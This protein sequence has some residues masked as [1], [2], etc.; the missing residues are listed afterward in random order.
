MK[1]ILLFG[2]GKSATVLIEYL[3]DNGPAH[4]W[5][6]IVADADKQLAQSKLDM[7]ERDIAVQLDVNDAEKRSELIEAADLIISL[8]PPALHYLIAL[9]CL[10]YKKHL[11]TAS[12]VDERIEKLKEEIKTNNLLFL[13]EMGLDPGIDHMS[14][15]KLIDAIH[16]QGGKIN[17]FISHCG[18]LVA[19][20]S[21]DNPWHYKISWNPKNVVNAGKA[22]AKFKKDGV[23]AEMDYHNIFAEK[24]YVRNG[25]E[26]YCWYP[27]RDSLRYINLYSLNEAP[28]FIRTTLRHPDF[29]Y[30]WKNVVDLKLTDENLFYETDGCSLMAFFKEHMDRN[31]FNQWLEQKLKQQFEDTQT[32]LNNLVNLV[33]L[34]EQASDEAEPIDDLMMVNEKGDLQN[35]DMDDLKNNAA[36]TIAFKMH[37]SKLT[38]RQLFYLGMDDDKTIINK[39]KCS[40]ADI[41]QFSLETKLALSESDKDMIIMLHEIEYELEDKKHKIESSLTLIGEDSNKTAMAKTVGLPLGIA[42]KLILNGTIQL[43]GL[44]IPVS[45]EIYEPVMNELEE[46]GIS[47]L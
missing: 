28:T 32:L 7:S 45:K 3:V 17:S 47:F 39:S 30:G 25:D 5:R 33:K 12:Y 44:Q 8:L 21:D 9:D 42:A 2:A 40:A 1:T 4:N 36:A 22:G 24:R 20:E 10:Q 34:Q 31:N 27:N 41:L 26:I 35:I 46:Y 13:C 6:L 11:L 38:L 43:R 29:I 18:G 23:I 15:K 37:E 14:A 19:P 16:E